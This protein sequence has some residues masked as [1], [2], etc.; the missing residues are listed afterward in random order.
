MYTFETLTRSKLSLQRLTLGH[1]LDT[2]NVI[3][4]IYY[5][6][7]VCRFVKQRLAKMIIRYIYQVLFWE[8]HFVYRN[9]IRSRHYGTR[10]EIYLTRI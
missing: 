9:S 6:N 10:K 2:N 4:Q 5:Q 1:L 3:L 7:V 8:I